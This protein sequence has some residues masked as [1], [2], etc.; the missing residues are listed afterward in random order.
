LTAVNDSTLPA[1]RSTL[2]A[3][4]F[5]QPLGNTN[6]PAV[7][8]AAADTFAAASSEPSPRRAILLITDGRAYVPGVPRSESIRRLQKLVGARL[9]PSVT[10]DALILGPVE[11][12]A[13]W[14]R[15]PH[16]RIH[17]LAH[18]RG[19][20]LAALYG[21][22]S[23]LLGT[24]T[25]EHEIIG[26]LDTIVLPPYLDLVVFD[27]LRDPSGS[28][29]SVFA[30]GA[31]Q[32]LDARTHGVE[33]VRLGSAFSTVAI[34]RPAA[35]AWTFRKTNPASRVRVLTQQFFPRGTLIGP[36]PRSPLRQY[37]HVA[38][39]YRLLDGNGASLQEL[40]AYP[41]SV[42]VTL[43]TPDGR[44]VALPM[45]RADADAYR[46]ASLTECDMPGRYWTEVSVTAPDA[47]G[48]AVRVFED[49]WSGFAVR[50]AA[51][52][53]CRL[54]AAAAGER[55]RV[56]CS[57]AG[58]ALLPSSLR[59]MVHRGGE[60]MAP[61]VRLEYRGGGIFEGS[62]PAAAAPGTY[63]LQMV[64]EPAMLDMR[65]LPARLTFIRP[66]RQHYPAVAIAVAAVAFAV[67]FML[68]RLYV[69][70]RQT[71]VA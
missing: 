12:D 6:F 15:V 10:V 39:A 29:V 28:G 58:E 30:P 1:I 11:G 3:I 61:D 42:E 54:S 63:A 60:R 7:F 62:L 31:S 67:L 41:L 8:G 24:S 5:R 52:V 65:V 51:R 57:E 4:D 47:S 22:V 21:V 17:H 55:V 18:D 59:V 43:A 13:D 33:E 40:A 9:S 38:I 71:R 44:R 70:R 69:A 53:D 14:Q 2:S 36:D 20:A 45:K 35:G 49:R 46:T 37:E 34:H 19:A 25:Q 56:E 64:T 23:S 50:L 48:R 27:I 32:P 68:R 26:A 16:T 66:E